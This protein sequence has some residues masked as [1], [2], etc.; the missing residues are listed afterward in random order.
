MVAVCTA[1]LEYM[2]NRG[3]QDGYSIWGNRGGQDGYSIKGQ[4]RAACRWSVENQ[5]QGII[6]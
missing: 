2:G 3:G 1:V 5:G 4:R 6:V